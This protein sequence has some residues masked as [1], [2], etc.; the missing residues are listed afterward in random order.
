MIAIPIICCALALAAVL[1]QLKRD[2]M[3]LQQ[4]S[5][6]DERYTRWMRESRES[7]NAN[8]LIGW[9][10]FLAA[11]LPMMPDIAGVGL[12]GAFALWQTIRLAMA[13][14]K[15][16]LVFTARARRIYGT[17]LAVVAVC[18]AAAGAVLYSQIGASFL[19]AESLLHYACAYLIFIFSAS[20]VAI[21]LANWLLQPVERR[22][23]KKYY[24]EAAAILASMPGLKVVGVT[25]S[26]GKTST[27]HYLE[28]ML[29]EQYDVL[30]TPGNFNTTL[31]VVRTVRERMKPY[32]EVFIVEMGAKQRG[33][34]RE[35]CD[36]VHPT[37]GI[38]TAVGPMHLESFGSIENV[39]ATKFELVDALPAD[40]LAIVNDDFEYIAN[41]P[42]DGP[43]C[44][45]Y[46]VNPDRPANYHA[47]D[48]RYTPTG[49]EF[50]IADEHG[51]VMRLRTSLVGEC[52]VSN[53]MAAAI[54]A[55]RL[56]VPSEKIRYAVEKLEQVEHR[57][58]IKRLPNGLTLIDDAYN[59]NPVG[60][61]MAMDVLA[62]MPGGRKF[63]IT[64]GMIEL[65]DDQYKLNREL[66][67][68]A[69]AAADV[70]IVVGQYN[71]DAIMDGIAQAGGKAQALAAPTFDQAQSMMLG[72]AQAGDIVLYEN[73]LPDT[74]K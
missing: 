13:K 32:N 3:M 48:V 57:L 31:G 73:D 24:D 15:K 67:A 58:S 2:L 51:E 49:T 72:M 30:M 46:A 64:P 10:V 61:K 53:L 66:G 27:K 70:V 52:N 69:A 17:A 26:Y 35:I 9:V 34:I 63:V 12:A 38:V 59:S 25:G 22:I 47:V 6:R 4:N 16:P 7:T 44:V 40:G 29:S 14:S 62:Q 54:A 39:Q 43:E 33:D 74:F 71:H 28:R 37:V 1:M 45:R 20:T 55:L 21:R 5:Y 56:G 11:L 41:R 18:Y 42:V 50:A 68:N 8:R 23:V 19:T 36:L 60:S 65:G